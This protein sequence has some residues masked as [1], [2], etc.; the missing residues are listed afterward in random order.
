MKIENT[1]LGQQE[2]KGKVE[3]ALMSVNTVFEVRLIV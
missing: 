2:R 1:S 3:Q